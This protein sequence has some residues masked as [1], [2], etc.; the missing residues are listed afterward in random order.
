MATA[1]RL[2]VDPTKSGVFHC[3]SRCVRRAFL[4][5]RDSYSGRNY[6]HR[7]AWIRDRL[8]ELTGLFGIEVFSYTIMSNHLHVVLRTLPEQV[9]AWRDQEVARRWLCL[10]PGTG[11]KARY[12][13]EESAIRI[14]CEDS[15]RLQIV[16]A[17][18]AD[19]S[20]FMR[21]LN[22]VIA[23]R[24]NREDDCTGRFWEGRFKCQR[25]DDEGAT[26]ACMAYVDLNPV[27]AGVA[28]TL[29][30]SDFTSAQDRVAAYRARQQLSRTPRHPTP[31]QAQCIERAKTEAKR[32][33]W[34]A[35][36]GRPV[37]NGGGALDAPRTNAHDRTGQRA[38]RLQGGSQPPLLAHLT[39]K[40]YLELLDWTGRQIHH[41]K[42]GH[43]S[44]ELR[45]ALE[46][47]DLDIEAW[48]DN[49][50]RFGG[51]FHHM[52][53][54]LRRLRQMARSTGRSWL[55]GHSG[56]RRLYVHPA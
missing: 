40:R 55:H 22:E 45:P 38:K 35:P 17:R 31:A 1:R 11:H 47:L 12:P 21:C 10:F 14:L 53:G 42:P 54:K 19:L 30:H 43:L 2:L 15:L 52:A 33:A 13:P 5:G 20:W 26:L 36:I 29:K 50:E 25:L 34:L 8:Q 39:F 24:A 46:R 44:R 18:L 23:R 32:D 41:D 16:R 3:V 51:L 37:E 56:A 7:R 49:V 4:C 9:D 27:R 6:E 28:T 48:V